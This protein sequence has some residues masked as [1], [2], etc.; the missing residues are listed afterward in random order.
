MGTCPTG[1]KH[2]RVSGGR[3]VC[4]FVGGGVTPT[5]VVRTVSCAPPCRGRAARVTRSRSREPLGQC[6]GEV[7]VGDGAAGCPARRVSTQA[8]IAGRLTEREP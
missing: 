6:L 7:A 8:A 2:V 4:G 5:V 3:R 1:L